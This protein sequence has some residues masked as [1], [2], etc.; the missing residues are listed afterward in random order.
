GDWDLITAPVIA[1]RMTVVS[2]AYFAA[3]LPRHFPVARV[4]VAPLGVGGQVR[5]QVQGEAWG[6]VRS[7]VQGLTPI[8]GALDSSRSALIQRALGRARDA[9]ARLEPVSGSA[10]SVLEHADII[11][12][13]ASQ[14]A[15][16]HAMGR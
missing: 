3:R 6:Q 13:V 8:V 10:E 12:A 5:S 14:P 9:G 4:R 16:D 15:D 11:I 2:D 7:Q 1:S